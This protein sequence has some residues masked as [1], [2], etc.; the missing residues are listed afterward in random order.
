MSVTI[1]T[2]P[3]TIGL[4][5]ANWNMLRWRDLL[6][7]EFYDIETPVVW[8]EPLAPELVQAIEAGVIRV[9]GGGSVVDTRLDASSFCAYLLRLGVEMPNTPPVGVIDSTSRDI[10]LATAVAWLAFGDVLSPARVAAFLHRMHR[11]HLMLCD[12]HAGIVVLDPA[13]YALATEMLAAKAA[14]DAACEELEIE[15]RKLSVQ[16]YAA[17]DG[18]ILCA[19]DFAAPIAL[20]VV[21]GRYVAGP[22]AQMLSDDWYRAVAAAERIGTVRISGAHLVNTL[23][24]RRFNALSRRRAA[25]ALSWRL[26]A[27]RRGDG[28]MPTRADWESGRGVQLAGSRHAAG[29]V[30]EDVTKDP[31]YAE[32]RKAGRRP[33]RVIDPN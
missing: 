19:A 27:W 18:R 24:R 11:V 1:E 31:R 26:E 20:D 33:K 2:S 7:L 8:D 4:T 21:K 29:V 22:A 9:T 17:D 5:R 6:F 13:T 3:R 16:T 10:H 23:G 30:W 28:P 14:F 25:A 15:I 32:V 12:H